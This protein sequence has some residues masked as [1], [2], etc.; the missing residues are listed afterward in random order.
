MSKIL[1][2]AGRVGRSMAF[3][4]RAGPDFHFLANAQS[5]KYSDLKNNEVQVT[6]QDS[7]TQDRVSVS[8]TAATA[9]NSDP[10]IKE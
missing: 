1:S 4:E 8:G 10:P 6:F 9:S 5:K 3:T 7:K 2:L